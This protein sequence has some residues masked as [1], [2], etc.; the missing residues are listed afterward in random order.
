MAAKETDRLHVTHP[1]EGMLASRRPIVVAG[2][3]R[4]LKVDESGSVVI[5]A[6]D[7]AVITLPIAAATGPS[8]V[9]VGGWEFFI[10]N[11][12]AD[13]GVGVSVDPG[14]ATDEIHGE[15][16]NAA[17]DS[18]ASGVAGKMFTNTK[19]TAKT[20]DFLHLV[21]DGTD[22]VYIVGGKGIWASEA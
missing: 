20:G 3:T 8:G 15:V 6:T 9:A 17:A 12:G 18:V 19:G 2:A 21:A 13:G 1:G 10:V 11:A 14:N 16:P 4:T 5:C 22:R 7:G